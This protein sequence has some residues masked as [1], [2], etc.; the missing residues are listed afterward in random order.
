MI[1]KKKFAPKENKI[2]IVS[3]KKCNSN[4]C[5]YLLPP[6]QTWSKTYISNLIPNHPPNIFFTVRM[7]SRVKLVTGENKQTKENYSRARQW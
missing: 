5:D 6:P 4:H 3:K 1:K 7:R 2:M